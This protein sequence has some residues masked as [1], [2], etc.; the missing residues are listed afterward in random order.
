MV[1]QLMNE[2]SFQHNGEL[3]IFSPKH[4]VVTPPFVVCIDPIFY[5]N[6]FD[7]CASLSKTC[8]PYISLRRQAFIVS[9]AYFKFD[10]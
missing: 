8:T 7:L 3:D 2:L 4:K 9:F 6:F 5:S 1:L 10:V